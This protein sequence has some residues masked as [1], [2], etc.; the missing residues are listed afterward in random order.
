MRTL[1]TFAD[2]EFLKNGRIASSRSLLTRLAPPAELAGVPPA[3]G[4][5]RLDHA[6][7]ETQLPFKVVGQRGRQM[8]LQRLRI[9]VF[10]AM[11]LL[12]S[13]RGSAAPGNQP[14]A[15]VFG[16]TTVTIS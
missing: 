8:F 3:F 13:S 12:W 4:Q 16:P 1:S 9:V 2:F 5:H 10:L 14:P 7:I 15:L 6:D 11:T